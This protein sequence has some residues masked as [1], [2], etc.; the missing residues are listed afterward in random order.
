MTSEQPVATRSGHYYVS[1]KDGDRRGL[2][3]GP[4]AQHQTALDLVDLVRGLAESVDCK[5]VFYSFG[6]AR[7]KDGTPP[8]PG[9]VELPTA[10]GCSSIGAPCLSDDIMYLPYTTPWV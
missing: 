7:A 3:A 6:T 4:F 10:R 8:P 9:S 1:V 5:A 2:L